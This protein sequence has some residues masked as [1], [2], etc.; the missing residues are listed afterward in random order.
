ML[1]IKVGDKVEWRSGKF[2]RTFISVVKR[3]REGCLEVDL[4]EENWPN[5]TFEYH[6]VV[7]IIPK[8]IS[9]PNYR[10]FLEIQ[11]KY[12]NL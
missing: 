9:K 12:V 11:N 3:K 2:G 6:R 4:H 7:R 5:Y 8:E 1:D 10:A